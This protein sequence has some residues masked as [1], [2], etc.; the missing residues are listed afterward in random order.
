[1]DEGKDEDMDGGKDEGAGAGPGAG[2]GGDRIGE[3]IH[4]VLIE[5][6]MKSSYI[7]Y[8]M[9]V[10][11]SR[12]LPDARDGLKPVQRRIL[13]AMNDLSLYHDRPYRKSAKIT[14]DVT[15]NYHPHG[16]VTVYDTMVRLVQDFSLRYPLIEG[17]GNFGSVDGDAA[18]AERYTEARLNPVAEELLLDL[19]KE[20]VDHRPNYD[21]TKNEPVVLP[22]NFPN[23][24]V[25]GASGIAVG[26]A[27]NIPPHN[28]GE[29]VD[30]LVYLIDTP[31]ATVEELMRF[32]PGP[33]FPT[34]GIILGRQGIRDAYSTGRGLIVVRARAEIDTLKNGKDAIVVTE[35]PYQVNKAAMIEK[36]AGLVK[37]GQITGISD[38]RDESDRR[39]MR[40]IIELRRDAQPR[41]V[42]NQLYKHTQMQTTFGANLL[43]L[44]DN[45][46]VVFGLRGMLQ[47][48]LDHR[49]EVIVRR[50]R[51]ELAQAEAR[52]HILEGLRRALD[53]LD[54][55]IT[56][57]RH[58]PDREAAKQG[59]Q[60]TF[61]LSELQ[62]AAILE[63]Q[64]RQL[65][66][67]ERNKIEQ[68]YA[69]VVAR[70]AELRE[71]LA[72]RGRVLSLIRA[73]MLS[74]KERFGDARRSE[75]G[76]LE[77]ETGFDIED[78]IPV[79]DMV[80]TITH[81][82]YIRRTRVKEYRSQGR[83]GRGLRGATTREDDFVEHLFIAS[84]HT[85]LLLFTDRGRAYWLKVHEI[86]EGGRTAKGRSILNLIG[87]QK[88]ER[89]AAYVPVREFRADRFLALATRQG[90][91]KKI[92]LSRFSHPRRKGIVALDL[93]EGDALISARQLEPGWEVIIGTRGGRAI[94]FPESDVRPMGRSAAGVRGVRLKGPED[95]AIGMV[96][97]RDPAEHLLVV[98]RKGFGK[99]SQIEDYRLTRRG[100]QGVLTIRASERNGP[101]VALLAVTDTDELMVMNSAG[102]IIRLKIKDVS[103]LSRATQ[104]VKLIQLDEGDYVR[105]VTRLA[106]DVPGI[107][108]GAEGGEAPVNGGAA[109]AAD[110]AGAEDEEPDTAEPPEDET[111]DADVGDEDTEGDPDDDPD[112]EA[113]V[114][115][116]ADDELGEDEPDDDEE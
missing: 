46:P 68:E 45:R 93:K 100:G 8:S 83:G 58:S 32:L 27:T 84:T 97:V 88:E 18:A 5:D 53:E 61:G 28:L 17:Q 50:S 38:L 113:D 7:D 52:A 82:G 11:V 4:P 86:P 63:M 40:V 96:V 3:R 94:R 19:D 54:A 12:A 39:G 62:A 37:S 78:L 30:A 49:V 85:Y 9:S 90:L 65:T 35:I 44:K 15:G 98:T 42:L 48:F 87:A 29:T 92:R 115:E 22:A 75:I 64:L 57:I 73:D 71:I 105:D 6:E 91:I 47:V 25:N 1:M 102:I 111:G 26:M 20:T 103:V 79:E 81:A 60:E 109:E 95:A 66:G 36:I 34:G 13:V 10:I 33:D 76:V 101:I 72:D 106:K 23:L 114:D 70:I 59:L 24:L 77:G 80:I 2:A 16:T 89:I 51:F 41:V 108:G 56:L 112:D 31:G 107:G 110:E 116:D 67:L 99:R 21:E 55:V 14:G 74:L 43:A 69:Q 104:G